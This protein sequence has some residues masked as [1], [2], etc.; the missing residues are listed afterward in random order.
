[1]R[2]PD[3][4]RVGLAA[5]RAALA[6]T[7]LLIVQDA[8]LPSVTTIVTGAPV[9]G[10]WWSHEQAHS[11]FD[12]LEALEPRTTTAKLL[13]HKQTLV[14]R[15]LHPELA[16]VGGARAAW[17]V[18]GLRDDARDLLAAVADA[19][20][21]V[22]TD[23]LPATGDRPR[24]DVVRDLER[25]L[26]VASDEIHTESGR[27][28]KVLQSWDA[29]ATREHLGPLPDPPAARSTFERSL[30]PVLVDAGLRRSPFPWPSEDPP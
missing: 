6:G 17:Q 12:V 21:A 5:C 1:V 4:V 2:D 8:V 24:A 22:R 9:R 11:I 10:S 13:L 29:W 15:R 7:G 3:V 18:D 14:D 20:G 19:G 28:A 16:A 27:H 25:R 23:E 30:Q 26:L